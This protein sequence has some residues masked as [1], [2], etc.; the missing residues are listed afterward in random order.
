MNLAAALECAAVLR[1]KLP[2]HAGACVEFPRE[3]V[4]LDSRCWP[5]SSLTDDEEKAGSKVP[6]S[7]GGVFFDNCG[8]QVP[9]SPSKVPPGGIFLR[10][11][12]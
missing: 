3:Y 1:R 6:Q 4:D 12:F 9:P 5:C 7:K 11:T 2:C 8:T 10:N